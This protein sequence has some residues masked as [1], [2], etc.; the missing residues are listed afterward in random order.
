MGLVVPTIHAISPDGTYGTEVTSVLS[1]GKYSGYDSSQKD[2]WGQ[3]SKPQFSEG[4]SYEHDS[5][6]E[7]AGLAGMS[8][9]LDQAINDAEVAAMGDGAIDVSFAEETPATRHLVSGE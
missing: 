4:F 7:G 5:L 6:W 3:T 9:V 1:S 2:R 8:A